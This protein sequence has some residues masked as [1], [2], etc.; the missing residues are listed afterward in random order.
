MLAFASFE[1]KTLFPPPQRGHASQRVGGGRSELSGAGDV[2]IG[3]PPILYHFFIATLG[4]SHISSVPSVR[5]GP[6]RGGVD[7]K[8]TP[9]S[10]H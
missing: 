6:R 7:E 3:R 2:C 9:Q 10:R 5:A 1:L 8:L 4:W